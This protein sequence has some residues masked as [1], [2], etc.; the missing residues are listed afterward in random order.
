MCATLVLE[1]GT[2]VEGEG[3]GAERL[4][5]G[6]L[7]FNTSMSGYQ[8]SLTDPSY[9]GQILMMTYPLIGNYGINQKNFESNKIQAEGFV[10]HEH[11]D[12]PSHRSSD[13]SISQF[14]MENDVPGICGV[15]TRMLTIKMRKHGTLRAALST[16]ENVDIDDLLKKIKNMPYP[17]KNNLVSEVSCSKIQYIKGNSGC[18]VVLIDCG[19]KNSILKHILLHASVIRVPYDITTDEICKLKPDGLLI[20]NG[21]GNP[22]HPDILR[23]TVKTLKELVND[24]PMMGICLGHQ[25]LSLAFG[26]NTY[27]LKFGHRGANQPVKD[28]NGRIRITAQ[29]H[30]FAVHP[31]TKEVEVVEKN[32]NDDSV[33]AVKHPDLPIFGVQYHPEGSPGPNDSQHLFSEFISMVRGKKI[34]KGEGF[35]RKN[36]P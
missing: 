21:P 25:L 28:V 15:D 24:H 32:V 16:C 26:T 7:V 14:L 11:Y 20:S 30:G 9:K 27:K 35:A 31:N 8:E 12:L 5:F 33:E 23:T 29:N 36:R 1:D 4:V 34:N 6:E 13:K 10:V 19:V 2:V 18:S 3:F 22:A 17:D